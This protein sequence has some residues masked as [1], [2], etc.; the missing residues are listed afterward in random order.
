MVIYCLILCALLGVISCAELDL[1]RLIVTTH[2]Y[3]WEKEQYVILQN[4]S[5]SN[6]EFKWRQSFATVFPTDFSVILTSATHVTA[7]T[8]CLL[9]SLLIKSV[10]VDS[11]NKIS[12]S[13]M[14]NDEELQNAQI[15]D[16]NSSNSNRRAFEST[17]S[18]FKTLLGHDV[19]GDDVFVV[20]SLTAKLNSNLKGQNVK[21]A[22]FDTGLNANHPDF[23]HIKER[24]DWT[25]EN[26]LNDLVGH[27]SFVSR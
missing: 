24:V 23:K 26:D 11:L 6:F 13:N 9:S 8:S 16:W 4:A 17:Y 18:S 27:G 5:C 15:Y 10:T 7:V 21:V 14:E 12:L 19:N 22:V 2:S 1:C 3:F 20:K 25:N